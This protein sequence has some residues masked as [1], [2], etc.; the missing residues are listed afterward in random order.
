MAENVKISKLENSKKNIVRFFKEVRNELKKVIW[1]NRTQLTKS[2]ITVLMS[3]FVIG[4]IIW[5][6][7]FVLT[8]GVEKVFNLK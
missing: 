8:L 3:C 4:F 7:D 6:F 1:P 5:V 2:T